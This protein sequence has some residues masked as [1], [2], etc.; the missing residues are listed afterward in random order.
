MMM[1]YSFMN[2]RDEI[3]A[4]SYIWTYFYV[5]TLLPHMEASFLY[6]LDR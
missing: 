1:N 4:I 6:L 5:H 2:N 3:L